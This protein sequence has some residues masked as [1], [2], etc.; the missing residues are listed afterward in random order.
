[1]QIDYIHTIRVF[2]TTV[3]EYGEQVISDYHD[4]PAVFEETITF[5][6]NDYR[7]ELD[8]TSVAL[9][10]PNDT[11]VLEMGRRMEEHLCVANPFDAPETQQWFKVSSVA[12][13]QYHQTSRQVNT[14][15]V[16]LKK[17]R[18]LVYVS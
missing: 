18:P 11:Y 6:H 2:E 8:A 4:I 12:I 17:T 9:F 13:G 14:V 5:N 3:D 7:D 15:Y 10:D 16:T 1:M